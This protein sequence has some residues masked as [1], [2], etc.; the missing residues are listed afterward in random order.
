MNANSTQWYHGSPFRLTRLL[1]GSTITPDR[2]L[3]EIFSHKPA[4]VSVD[5]DGTIKHN[6]A[7]EG[8]LYV[9]AE[10]ILPGDVSPHPHTS[11]QP[12]KEWLTQRKLKVDLIGLVQIVNEEL[13]TEEEIA[14]LRKRV[15]SS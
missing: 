8:L 12:G 13:L 7:A 1:P 10:E 4:F 11:M 6:G 5:D 9:V 3:A 2:H 14:E 15:Q